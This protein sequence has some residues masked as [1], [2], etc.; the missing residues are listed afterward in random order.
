MLKLSAKD[1]ERYLENNELKNVASVIACDYRDLLMHGV[2]TKLIRDD[3]RKYVK[4]GILLIGC[5]ATMAWFLPEVKF[6]ILGAVG[7]V[8]GITNIIS[9]LK[10][11]KTCKRIMRAINISLGT[12][13]EAPIEDSK[14]FLESLSGEDIDNFLSRTYFKDKELF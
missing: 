5:G 8:V 7:V 11:L 2:I 9:A 10:D 1:I 6:V 14:D 3:E 12:F 13:C 4:Q